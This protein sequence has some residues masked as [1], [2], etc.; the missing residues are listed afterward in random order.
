MYEELYKYGNHEKGSKEKISVIQLRKILV[1][2]EYPILEEGDIF[3][4]TEM[5]IYDYSRYEN[6][7]NFL[8]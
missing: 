5:G 6:S 4:G 1:E 3:R 7:S 2:S 8:S